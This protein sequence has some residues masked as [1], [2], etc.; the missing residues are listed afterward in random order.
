MAISYMSRRSLIC[1]LVVGLAVTARP[2]PALSAY[3]PVE[4]LIAK[5]DSLAADLGGE[6][7]RG[8]IGENGIL[9]GAA[10]GRL[11]EV[12]LELRANGQ[13]EAAAENLELAEEIARVHESQTGSTAPGLLVE[14]YRAWSDSQRAVWQ[15]ARSL[16][17]AATEA[18]SAGEFDRAISLLNDALALYDSI[19][20]SRS[21]AVVWG[22]L[23][24]VAWYQGD[25]ETVA[26]YY[27]RA[28]AARREIEDRILEGKTLNG[29]GSVN[30]QLGNFDLAGV[31]RGSHQAQ[32]SHRR[33]GR[34][35]DIAQLSG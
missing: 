14:T 15:E 16:E 19:G 24:V 9:V 21:A 3:D 12:A 34:P 20:D 1:I 7:L 22:S 4:L 33:H 5:A 2:C 13:V 27:E 8:L 10:V 28:L 30:L 35:G 23:G 17:A 6:G 11:A 29:L 25:F 31:L 32:A 18:R 26:F